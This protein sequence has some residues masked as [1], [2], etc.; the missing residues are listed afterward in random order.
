MAADLRGHGAK[1]FSGGYGSYIV[2]RLD[3]FQKE[4]GACEKCKRP[5]WDYVITE[6]KSH[7][8]GSTTFR[9]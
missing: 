9:Q 2:R 6:K 3:P 1:R 7:Q 5:G 4:K 8:P